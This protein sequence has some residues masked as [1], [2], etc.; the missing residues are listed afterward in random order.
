MAI[1]EFW[2]QIENRSMSPGSKCS[3]QKND[4]GP[5]YRPETEAAIKLTLKPAE[6]R[7]TKRVPPR[8]G[9]KAED[10]L[11]RAMDALILRRYR[12]PAREDRSDAWTV[13]DEPRMHSGQRFV[14]DLSDQG[15]PGP[16]SGPAIE[17]NIGDRVVVHFR[18][19]DQRSKVVTKMIEVDLPFGGSMKLATPFNEA[20]PMED[21]THGLRPHRIGRPAAKA[22][23]IA[24]LLPDPMQPVGSEAWLWSEIGVDAFKKGDRVPPGGTFTYTWELLDGPRLP[25]HH[26]GK[27]ARFVI[28]RTPSSILEGC[29]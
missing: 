20:F 11:W 28:G 5:L 9:G 12:P 1:K 8:D 10:C 17:C 13:P 15:V 27:P 21:R 23:T 14:T 22:G 29:E 4:R 26:A 3:D 2:I 16:D 6:K 18:N 7:L 24:S 19:N 25:V